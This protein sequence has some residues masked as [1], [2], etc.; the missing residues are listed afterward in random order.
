M[1]HPLQKFYEFID[2]PIHGIARIV[3]AL[4]VVPLVLAFTAPLWRISMEAPQYPGGLWMDIYAYKI[5]G[6]NHGQHIAEIN[7]LN[8]YIGMHHIDQAAMSDLDWI[9]FALGA[10]VLIALRVAAIGNVR[11]LLDLAV[12]TSYV[13]LFALGRFVYRLYVFGHDLDPH[14]PVK[15]QPFMPVVLGTKQVANFT[16]HSL[17]RMGSVYMG[18]FAATV[19]GCTVW[20]LVA[21][22][23]DAARQEKGSGRQPAA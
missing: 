2:R 8:H 20:M 7:T 13:S 6:G 11:S 18:L 3:L 16:T 14:A 1:K 5:E 19:V 15:V 17:P 22:R 4:S 9:P 10:L 23:L 21:G 12:M